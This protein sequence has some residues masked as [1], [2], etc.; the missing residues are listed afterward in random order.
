MFEAET[1][2]QSLATGAHPQIA[3]LLVAGASR[4]TLCRAHGELISAA[5]VTRACSSIATH[6][7]L[8]IF[9]KSIRGR[10]TKSNKEHS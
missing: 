4:S 1:E 2:N 10:P 9:R 8:A 6:E 7:D 5:V 3:A